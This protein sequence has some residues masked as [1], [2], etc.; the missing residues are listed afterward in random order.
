MGVARGWLGL[1]V[2]VNLGAELD[3][4]WGRGVVI[5]FLSQA[6]HWP[7]RDKQHAFKVEKLVD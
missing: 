4:D 7:Q 6:Q 5:T 2:V 3:V 1:G